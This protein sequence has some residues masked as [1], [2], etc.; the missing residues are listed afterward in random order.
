MSFSP[1]KPKNENNSFFF[2][3]DLLIYGM[4]IVQKIINEYF[5]SQFCTVW[6]KIRQDVC[7]GKQKAV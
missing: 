2:P 7:G 3:L 6:D 4:R 1:V 5:F